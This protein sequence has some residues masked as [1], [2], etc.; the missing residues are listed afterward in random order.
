MR[1]VR[2]GDGHD[3]RRRVGGVGWEAWLVAVRRISVCAASALVL[4]ALGV[5]APQAASAASSACFGQSPTY[6]DACGPTFVL[7]GWGDAG[8]WTD[9]SQYSTIQLADVNGDGRDELLGRND[10]GLEVWTFDTAFGQWRPQVDAND[11]P[12]F[13]SDFRSPRPGETLAT[14]FTQPEYF[15]TIQAG[16]VDGQPGEEV[17]GRFADGLH[18]YK[19]VPPAGSTSIDG[20]SWQEIAAQGPFADAVGGNDPSVYS[21]IHLADLGA[22]VPVFFGRRR[23]TSGPLTWAWLLNGQW[24]ED[25]D[26]ENPLRIEAVEQPASLSEQHRDDVELELIEDTG[27]QRELR[28][29]GAVHRDLLVAGGLLGASHGGFDVGDVGHE[30]PAADVDPRLVAA[31]DEDR[32]AV[33]VIAAPAAGRLEGAGARHDRPRGVQL[34]EDL[35]VDVLRGV[36]GSRIA[37]RD[38]GWEPAVQVAAVV[39]ERILVP[40]FV[41]TGDEPVERD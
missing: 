28:D 41:R 22:S 2:A 40:A 18:V 11:V 3:V 4:W 14:D 25:S 13:V 17:V 26:L 21:T 38:A 6:T 1:S 35:A 27:R 39:A 23:V 31:E 29:R 33:V 37:G 20:G 8:G 16:D 10:Q 9:P 34:V 19:Y 15:A 12:E 30:R 24:G 5:V 7:P 32:H 36:P